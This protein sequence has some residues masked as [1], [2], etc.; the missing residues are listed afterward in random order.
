LYWEQ[1]FPNTEPWHV[2]PPPQP[3]L[4]DTLSAGIRERRILTGTTEEKEQALTV[5]NLQA[6]VSEAFTL[7]HAR[8]D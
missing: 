3:P 2:T 6:P 1:Q 8:K 7:G 5:V 4:V